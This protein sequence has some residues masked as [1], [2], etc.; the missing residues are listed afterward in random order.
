MSKKQVNFPYKDLMKSKKLKLILVVIFVVLALLFFDAYY[1]ALG[2]SIGLII[3]LL[4]FNSKSCCC[5]QRA[6]YRPHKIRLIA[7]SNK[8][9]Y[10]ESKDGN[11]QNL[12]TPF[13]SYLYAPDTPL[14]TAQKM[15]DGRFCGIK[16]AKAYPLINYCSQDRKRGASFVVHLFVVHIEEPND[17]YIDCK[18]NEGKWW[19]VNHLDST[20]AQSF[21]SSKIKEEL[22]C[23]KETILLAESLQ[24]K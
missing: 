5:E 16:R 4:V 15:I 9:I 1:Y 20:F 12:D 19:D 13:V 21:L 10:L 17:L 23:L 2:I 6:K 3:L 11:E 8:M 14:E 22:P 24:K 18:P 7:Y